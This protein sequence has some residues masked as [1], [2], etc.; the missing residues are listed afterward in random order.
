MVTGDDK[1]V[2]AWALANVFY[3]NTLGPSLV[4]LPTNPLIAFQCI[5]VVINRV[6][7]RKE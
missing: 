1:S 7:R 4:L 5:C 2:V 3:K 6:I